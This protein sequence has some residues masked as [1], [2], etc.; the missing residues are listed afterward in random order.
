M[1]AQ[2]W[3]Y[4]DLNVCREKGDMRSAFVTCERDWR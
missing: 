2:D 4:V 1:K 3:E